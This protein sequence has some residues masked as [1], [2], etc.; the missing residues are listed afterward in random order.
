MQG[1]SRSFSAGDDFRLQTHKVSWRHFGKS[2]HREFY[3]ALV[4][5][6][7]NE[8]SGIENAE[9]S[10]EFQVIVVEAH[11]RERANQD[12]RIANIADASL[13]PRGKPIRIESAFLAGFQPAHRAVELRL[14]VVGCFV[15][16]AKGGF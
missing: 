16:A 6:V 3:A 11:A 13:G 15:P 4:V 1:D 9:R 14:H 10:R 2:R 7:R 12:A 5:N 8:M